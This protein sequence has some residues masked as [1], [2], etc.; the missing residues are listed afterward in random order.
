MRQRWWALL[1]LA[2]DTSSCKSA[3]APPSSNPHVIRVA[4][5]DGGSTL[6]DLATGETLPHETEA[7][8]LAGIRPRVWVEPRDPEIRF[9]SASPIDHAAFS[10]SEPGRVLPEKIHDGARFLVRGDEGQAYEFS[11][12]EY[13][14]GDGDS[15]EIRFSVRSISVD[16]R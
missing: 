5:D 16:E 13:V 10:T 12:L 1:C 6:V 11:V 8:I 3:E 4:T 7:Q 2:L 14:A 15:A 9:L